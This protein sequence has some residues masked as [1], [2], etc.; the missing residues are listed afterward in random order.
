M[1]SHFFLFHQL[2]DTVVTQKKISEGL[3]A[4]MKVDDDIEEMNFI[5]SMK[6]PLSCM[7]IETP[8]RSKNCSHEQCFDLRVCF[9]ILYFAYFLILL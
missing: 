4:N 8:V 9:I 6:C 3:R 7:R 2:V 5:L 1:R